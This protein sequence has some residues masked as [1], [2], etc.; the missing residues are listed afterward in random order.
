MLKYRDNAAFNQ[1]HLLSCMY[2]IRIYN[3]HHTVSVTHGVLRVSRYYNAMPMLLLVSPTQY[4]G[5]LLCC[6]P[7]QWGVGGGPNISNLLRVPSHT[8][9]EVQKIVPLCLR[10]VTCMTL[11]AVTSCFTMG[12]KSPG[13]LFAFVR[14]WSKMTE[15]HIHHMA[16]LL[17]MYIGYGMLQI[18]W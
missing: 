12:C 13:W 16:T 2:V 8:G 6:H 3:I 10:P 1:R 17:R 5:T 7:V 4:K 14:K 15:N 9:P 18:L 11:D